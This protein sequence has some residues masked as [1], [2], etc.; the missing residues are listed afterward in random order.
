MHNLYT[1]RRKCEQILISSNKKLHT[2]PIPPP[3]SFL[4]G[5]KGSIYISNSKLSLLPAASGRGSKFSASINESDKK[6][7]AIL[8]L[9]NP[10]S[11]GGSLQQEC[12]AHIFVA[13]V[14]CTTK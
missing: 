11:Q 4:A 12:F 3:Q 8:S 9:Y 14:W 10:V 2:F 5:Q 1:F 7:N 13:K 6:T